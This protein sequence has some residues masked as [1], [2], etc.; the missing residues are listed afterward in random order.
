[1]RIAI[2]LI[3]IASF[4]APVAADQT[5][6]ANNLADRIWVQYS[7]PDTPD[8]PQPGDTCPNCNGAGKVGDGRVFSKCVP[9]DGTGKVLATAGSASSDDPRTERAFRQLDEI[10]RQ[11][12]KPDP[13]KVT[14]VTS[15]L[16]SML[17]LYT[18]ENCAPCER[19]IEEDLP[20]YLNKSLFPESFDYKVMR[21]GD[22][23]VECDGTGKRP[24]KQS[25]C[26][27]CGG[28]GVYEGR[29]SPYWSIYDAE[30]RR[31]FKQGRFSAKAL[32]EALDR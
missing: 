2:F 23:C 28:A 4:L 16:K 5:E 14:D 13:P 31:F 17:V 22:S 11:I 10:H 19:A 21:V 27:G 8:G 29:M 26:P 32:R 6:R 12:F 25:K 7:T 18:T 20:Q 1:M 9:C 30:G 3:L 15:G 24:G